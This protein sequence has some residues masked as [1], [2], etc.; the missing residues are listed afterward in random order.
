MDTSNRLFFGVPPVHLQVVSAERQDGIESKT[1]LHSPSD[2]NL[3]NISV[4]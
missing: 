4:F 3:H 2:T 1:T